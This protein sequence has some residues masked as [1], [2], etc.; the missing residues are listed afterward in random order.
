[1]NKLEQER[2]NKLQDSAEK[3][4]DAYHLFE[5]LT[6]PDLLLLL[7][8]DQH[9][10]ELICA[11][12]NGEK[13]SAAQ[14]EDL[15]DTSEQADEDATQADPGG[16]QEAE[17]ITDIQE[18]AP[19]AACDPLRVA[20]APELLLLVKVRADAEIAADW[21]GE[22]NESEGRQLIRLISR[23]SQWET[24]LDLWER[25]SARCKTRQGAAHGDERAL[26]DACLKIHNLIWHS[27]Q[28]RLNHAAIGSAYD[29]RLYLRGTPTGETIE[30]EWLPGL[31]NASGASQKLPLVAT[32]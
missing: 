16:R 24:I 17:G 31:I 12:V 27:R 7:K 20:I 10:H 21:L 23:A 13:N 3:G 26:L 8:E 28:A 32:R 14:V 15:P 30:A 29:Y 2:F 9:L 6:Y 19:R 22:V 1:M 5:K 11:I 18:P 4:I 25:L